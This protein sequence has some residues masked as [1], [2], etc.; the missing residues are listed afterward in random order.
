MATN[1]D[2]VGLDLTP[3]NSSRELKDFLQRLTGKYPDQTFWIS[4]V[5]TQC[6][7][8]NHNGYS[9]PLSLD[10]QARFL[11]DAYGAV[12]EI[13]A[14]GISVNSFADWQGAIPHL[15]PNG[16]PYLYSYG[17]VSYWRE[18]R[19]AFAVTR[20]LFSDETLPT[21]PI[22]DYADSP[23]ILYV[24]LSTLLLVLITYLHY[25]RRWFR[26]S[27]MRA[28]FRPYNFF[29][30][31][32]DQRMISPF[33]TTTV[34]LLVAAG[35]AT[36]LSSLCYAFRDSYLFDRFLGIFIPNDFLKIRM[37]FLIWH[38]AEFIL[39]FTVF[40]MVVV[41]VV[42][43]VIKL[44]SLAVKIRLQLVSAFTVATW[45]T[46]PMAVLILVDMILFRL[47][48]DSRFVWASWILLAA[49]FLWSLVRLFHGIGVIY[50]LPTIRVGIIGSVF[51]IVLIVLIT[52]YY[53]GTNG[54]IS[55]TKFF[56]H[57]LAQDKFI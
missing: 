54:V 39:A 34:L 16:H 57:F 35:I 48:G 3:F 6:Q 41:L 19:P 8:N 15:M 12:D 25:S 29:A 37:D 42:T 22:G 55:Y 26:E 23:P 45:S 47:L 2:F 20:A 28:I 21:L 40:G 53:N 27:A 32:R 13:G 10:H 52:V 38:P 46:L 33:Q 18:K 30:D 50:D 36:Y 5:G 44:L 4:S 7:M 1:A 56:Y 14:V 43:M 17:L 9:D 11:V 31:I 51:L 49:L 24:M